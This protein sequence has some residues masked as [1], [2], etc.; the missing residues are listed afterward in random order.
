VPEPE[1]ELPD[2]LPV[3]ELVPDDEPDPPESLPLFE[4]PMAMAAGAKPTV[5]AKTS[6]S[7]LRRFFLFM[8]F[9]H[10]GVCP[11]VGRQ[12]RARSRG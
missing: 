10:V 11:A 9:L 4:R 12:V 1:P 6:A 2:V 8:M 5:A 7:A 3:P